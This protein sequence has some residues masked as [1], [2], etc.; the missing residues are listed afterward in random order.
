MWISDQTA[1]FALYIINWL[2]FITVVESVYCAVR[3]DSLY[4]ADYVSSL[5]GLRSKMSLYGKIQNPRLPQ[6]KTKHKGQQSFLTVFNYILLYN[7]EIYRLF[8]CN[9]LSSLP[10][11]LGHHSSFSVKASKLLL[12]VYSIG[13]TYRWCILKRLAVIPSRGNILPACLNGWCALEG[14]GC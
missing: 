12:C 10:V 4:K 8:I 3:T 1:I 9:K 7:L 11:A 6:D 13:S 14:Q 2:V 5:K